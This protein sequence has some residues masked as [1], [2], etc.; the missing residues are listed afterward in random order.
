MVMCLIAKTEGGGKM[1]ICKERGCFGNNH[2]IG[3][4]YCLSEKA[5][6]KDGECKF[7]KKYQNFPKGYEPTEEELKAARERRTNNAYY[8]RIR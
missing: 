7:K 5:I 8:R 4:C 6:G 1:F 2:D 3:E